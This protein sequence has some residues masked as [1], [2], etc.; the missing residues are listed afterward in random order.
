VL[1]FMVRVTYT[2]ADVC[3]GDYG[4]RRPGANVRG[5]NILHLH[6]YLVPARM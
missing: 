2:W 5:T 1:E 4:G 6:L 3:S